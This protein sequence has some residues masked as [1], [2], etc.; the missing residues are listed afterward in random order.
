MKTAFTPLETIQV[1]GCKCGVKLEQFYVPGSHKGRVGEPIATQL[2]LKGVEKAIV[3]SSGNFAESIAFYTQNLPI[4]IRC[5]T[6]VLS[7]G[8]M[9]KRLQSYSHVE[10]VVINQ[11][12]EGGSHLQARLEYIKDVMEKDP[13]FFF[14]DQY[15]NFLL[16][17][18]YENTLAEEIWKQTKG[19]VSSLFVPCGTGGTIKGLASYFKKRKPEVRIF[20][21]DARGSH[22]FRKGVGKRKLPGYGNAKCTEL[23]KSSYTLIDWVI[24]VGDAEAV[25]MCH[26]LR[27]DFDLWVGA[28][29]GATLAAFCMAAVAYPPVLPDTGFPVLIFP[30]GGAAYEDS[31]YSDEWVE[32]NIFSDGEKRKSYPITHFHA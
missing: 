5:V 8:I 26:I 20:A 21:V 19:E 14:I 22:L 6:D 9:M 1:M 7:S 31:I 12:D 29:S 2:Q 24:P 30:D 23:A 16:P 18:I 3:S 13:N 27:R 25:E 11:P 28:S 4:S 32:R 10:L 17:I 15:Q